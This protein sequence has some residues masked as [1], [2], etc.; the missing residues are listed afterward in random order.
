MDESNLSENAHAL[1]V[2]P[3]PVKDQL[4]IDTDQT[5]SE[6]QI[7]NSMGK[8]ISNTQGN[9]TQIGMGSLPRG[10]YIVRITFEDGQTNI[11]KIIKQ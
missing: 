10:I 9:V 8:L 11:Q 1:R 4:N 2:F 3:N 7:V 5:I 6:V